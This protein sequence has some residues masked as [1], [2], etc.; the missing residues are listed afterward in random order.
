LSKSRKN[1]MSKKICRKS[2]SRKSKIAK[3]KSRKTKCRKQCD[4]EKEKLRF[5]YINF[6]ERKSRKMSSHFTITRS[7]LGALYYYRLLLLLLVFGFFLILV[8][9][10]RSRNHHLLYTVIHISYN[11]HLIKENPKKVMKGMRVISNKSIK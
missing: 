3:W 5:S 9:I 1:K 8:Q 6:S 2:K 11:L 7:V 4:F 10:I